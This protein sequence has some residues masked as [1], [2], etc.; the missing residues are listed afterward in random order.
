MPATVTWDNEAHTILRVD[1]SQPLDWDEVFAAQRELY[2]MADSVDYAIDLILDFD[3]GGSV[4]PNALNNLKRLIN[5][6]H[7]RIENVVLVETHPLL[8]AIENKVH[9]IYKVGIGKSRQLSLFAPNIT[10]ARQMLRQSGMKSR[11]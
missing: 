5:D 3:Q 6:L 8:R 7:P 11:T 2:A 1:Y 9:D 10:E 4:L